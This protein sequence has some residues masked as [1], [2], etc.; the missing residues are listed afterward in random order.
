MRHRISFKADELRIPH[1]INSDFQLWE[2]QL[3]IN[4]C[5]ILLTTVEVC[6][7][8]SPS[9][10]IS[11][12]HFIILWWLR[13]ATNGIC[14]SVIEVTE[15]FLCDDIQVSYMLLIFYPLV[16]SSDPSWRAIEKQ[17]MPSYCQ[18]EQH[19]LDVCIWSLTSC[20]LIAIPRRDVVTSCFKQWTS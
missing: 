2:I 10:D 15:K 18:I 11:M 3:V 16:S 9:S 20:S 14:V 5:C 19:H 6:K 1:S 12:T 13:N 17:Q 4:E 8:V 7:T